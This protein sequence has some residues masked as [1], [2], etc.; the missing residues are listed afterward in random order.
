MQNCHG[1]PGGPG[2]NPAVIYLKPVSENPLG[3]AL[4][5]GLLTWSFA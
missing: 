3:A 5:K 1:T 4:L 2:Q